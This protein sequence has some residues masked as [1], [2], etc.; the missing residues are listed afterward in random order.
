GTGPG[1]G[2]G[3]GADAG[4]GTA[5][6][7]G[8]GTG[9]A[10]DGDGD[11]DAGESEGPASGGGTGIVPRTGPITGPVAPVRGVAP[12]DLPQAPPGTDFAAAERAGRARSRAGGGYGPGDQAQHWLKWR[13]GRRTNLDPR[14]T[15]DPRYMGPLQSS[16]S[17]AGPG[18][19]RPAPN[20]RSYATPHTYADRGLYPDFVRR[21]QSSGFW[22]GMTTARVQLV[23]AGRRTMHAMTGSRGPMPPYI[24]G[25]TLATAAGNVG[26]GLSRGLIGGV[27][28]G[29]TMLLSGSY[30]AYVN[31]FAGLSRAAF[32][33]ASYLPVAAAGFVGG[34]FVGGAVGNAVRGAGGSREDAMVAGFVAGA[35]TGALIGA[36]CGTVLPGVGNLAGY[37]V[38]AIV[39]GIAG[40]IGGILANW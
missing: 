11:G 32:L 16:R 23:E 24:F 3:S 21:V 39:G 29:E 34:G 1:A 35:A 20:G 10:S 28:E 17:L 22:R 9:A 4:G 2:S 5:P 36:V 33:G 31:G 18:Y 12:I 8:D 27:A 7:G 6:G 40:G 26:V 37:A 30:W 15:N 14:I 25:P 13:D 38:G 19:P